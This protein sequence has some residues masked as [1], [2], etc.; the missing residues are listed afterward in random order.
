MNLYPVPKHPPRKQLVAR[1][2]VVGMLIFGVG[3]ILL[4]VSN[5][6]NTEYNK[7]VPN[8]IVS[9]NVVLIATWVTWFYYARACQRMILE[10]GEFTYPPPK[11]F[12]VSII[13]A[14]EKIDGYLKKK[15]QDIDGNW[16]CIDA[17]QRQH[18]LRYE[19][20]W[21]DV[22]ADEPFF[23]EE[24]KKE[25]KNKVGLSLK[26]EAGPE[27]YTRL[28]IRFA[29]RSGYDVRVCDRKIA[30]TRHE[31]E[32]VLGIGTYEKPEHRLYDEFFFRPADAAEERTK[33]KL[34]LPVP[35]Y[36]L[37]AFSLI[38]LCSTAWNVAN[39][40]FFDAEKFVTEMMA[41]VVKER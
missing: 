19:I 22:P 21:S 40:P 29:A 30:E 9:T 17:D 25:Y 8:L 33:P 20:Q 2:F 26:M 35:P 39:P 31:L 3:V 12:P 38:L 10:R 6:N 16:K 32:Q 18:E 28:H 23:S 13:E 36:W 11:L 37:L 1:S 34:E 27:S 5:S 14:F 15:E 7:L 4:I 41:E 24:A